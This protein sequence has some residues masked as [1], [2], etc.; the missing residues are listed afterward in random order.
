MELKGKT[1]EL[2]MRVLP[3][4]PVNLALG[5][6]FWKFSVYWSIINSVGGL[7]RATQP[8]YTVS[9]WKNGQV[10]VV[11]KL[12]NWPVVKPRFFKAFYAVRYQWT[13]V[14][15]DF[16]KVNSVTKRDAYPLPQ[17]NG[18]WDKLRRAKYISTIDLHKGFLHIPLKGES[19]DRTA[20]SVPGRGL[21]PFKRMYFGLSNAH[22]TFQRLL[23][24]LICPEME[25]N[26]FA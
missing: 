10:T 25:P 5:L 13:Q 18:I 11:A 6:D 17:K 2:R 7:L 14:N 8:R 26:A 23:D 21:F 24:H 1:K 9:I 22:A 4:L 20:F 19:R 3:S 12:P 15:L 16:R